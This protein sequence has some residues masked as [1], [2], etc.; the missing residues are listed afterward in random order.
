MAYV[1]TSKNM[2]KRGFPAIALDDPLLS[3]EPPVAQGQEAEP[4]RESQM[5]IG[6]VDVSVAPWLLQVRAW[7]GGVAASVR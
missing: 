4:H 2:R 7:F 5:E 1:G 3:V 6:T